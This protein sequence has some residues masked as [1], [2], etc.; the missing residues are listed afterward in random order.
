[1]ADHRPQS[2]ERS[3][4]DVPTTSSSGDSS[5]H[6]ARNSFLI[7]WGIHPSTWN[8]PSSDQSASNGESSNLQRRYEEQNE[9]YMAMRSLSWKRQKREKL[10][11]KE[12]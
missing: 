3:E 6:S 10:K 4:R 8:R 7:R 11:R 5:S 1:M 12:Y 2:Y 9:K